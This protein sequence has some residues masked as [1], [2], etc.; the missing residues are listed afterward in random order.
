MG[1]L[2]IGTPLDWTESKQHI[3]AAKERGVK[4]FLRIYKRFSGI[5]DQPFRWGDEIEFSLI[6]FDHANKRAYLLLKANK[7]IPEL[8]KNSEG[9]NVVFHP[10]YS[11]YM[12]ETCPRMPFDDKWSVFCHL[13]ADF[14]H[15]RRMIE[16]IL[17]TDEHLIPI[18]CFP[19]L[20][21]PQFSYPHFE[22]TP[23]NGASRSLFVPDQVIFDGLPRFL[24]ITKNAIA[25]KSRKMSAHVPIFIDKFTPRPFREQFDEAKDDHVHLDCTAFGMGC[26]C[27]QVT[28]QAESMNEARHLYDQLTPFTPIALALTASSPIWRGYLTNT[29]ARWDIISIYLQFI[30]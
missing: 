30:L 1:L 3:R 15:R 25:R 6:K 23:D 19:L 10:E 5:R 20:G 18:T 21:C 24:A 2:T 9:S 28:F 8:K 29:D 12:V 16:A 7:L 22:P 13:E 17:P 11:N 4:E 27:L 14:E 26:C